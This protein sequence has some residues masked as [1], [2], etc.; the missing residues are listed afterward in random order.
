MSRLAKKPIQ[1]PEKVDA[2]FADGVLTIKGPLGTLARPVHPGVTVTVAD[3]AVALDA[4]RKTIETRALLGT[5]AAHVRNMIKGVTEGF[6][7]QLLIEGTGYKAKV[8]GKEIILSIGFSHDVPVMIPE[9][10]TVVVDKEGMKISGIDI[11]AVG[12]FSAQVRDWKRP[13]PY[14]GKG[15]RYSDEVIERKQGKKAVA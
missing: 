6:S 10:I 15:I 5:F 13:E 7:K 4:P 8:Q 11:E 9:G 2:S 1:L 12:L 3:R 14:K